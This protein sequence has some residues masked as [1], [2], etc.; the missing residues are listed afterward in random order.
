MEKTDTNL[1]VESVEI[2]F[3]TKELF[4]N[5]LHYHLLKT[6]KNVTPLS[7][8]ERG[9]TFSLY[10]EKMIGQQDLKKTFTDFITTT[11]LEIGFYDLTEPEFIYLDQQPKIEKNHFFYNGLFLS[12]KTL[13]LEQILIL[14]NNL[15]INK[16]SRSLKGTFVKK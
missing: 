16:R 1:N 10:T 2:P 8:N 13:P 6:L 12:E 15:Q 3:K 11:P 14:I 5:L 7:Y 9:C 4:Y